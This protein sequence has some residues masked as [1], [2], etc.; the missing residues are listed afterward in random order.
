MEI[1]LKNRIAL[2]TG[3]AQG[4]GEGVAL[5]LARAGADIV[6]CDVLKEKGQA[7]ADAVA[8]LGRRSLFVH[9]DVSDP[10]AVA[11]MMDQIADFG[12]LDIIVNNA[13]VE[14]FRTLEETTIEEWDRTQSVNLKSIFLSAKAALPLL[15]KSDH[16]III[17]IASVHATATIPVLAAY[18]ATKG[19]IV[20]LTHSLAQDLGPQGIRVLTV[21]PGFIYA[22]M[23]AVWLE[24]QEDTQET[25]DRVNAMHPAGRIGTPEDIGN[26]CAFASSEFGGFINGVNVI[27]DGG[28]T[29]MLHH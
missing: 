28:L 9:C 12:G 3:S 18:A 23:T 15:K 24:E 29:T 11:A 2:V 8:A 27:I 10:D 21:S 6:V 13:A 19:G 25:L 26:F 20:S 14:Y 5:V 22:G 17:N 1:S 4:I 7:T 16:A